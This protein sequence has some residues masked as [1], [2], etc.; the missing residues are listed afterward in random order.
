M[1]GTLSGVYAANLANAS[2]DLANRMGGF[3][4]VLSQSGVNAFTAARQGLDLT[5]GPA[6]QSAVQGASNVGSELVRQNSLRESNMFNLLGK[7]YEADAVARENEKVRRAELTRG[8]LANI[9]GLGQVGSQ[10]RQIPAAPS[11]LGNASATLET[12]NNLTKSIYD[13][14]IFREQIAMRAAA[15]E[16]SNSRSQPSDGILA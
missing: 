14:P 1:A 8:L 2:T 15:L 9:S 10:P 12:F 16:A 11:A 4:D 5:L 7:A 13:N 3:K 6:I